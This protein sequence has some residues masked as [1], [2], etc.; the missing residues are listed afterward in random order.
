MVNQDFI[1]NPPVGQGF[2]HRLETVR[3]ITSARPCQH[4]LTWAGLCIWGTKGAH[5]MGTHV[6]CPWH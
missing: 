1:G 6:P 4:Q 3:G 2:T 5:T